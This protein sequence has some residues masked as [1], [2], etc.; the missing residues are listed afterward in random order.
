MSVSLKHEISELTFQVFH[1]PSNS[2][3]KALVRLILLGLLFC[4]HGTLLAEEAANESSDIQEVQGGI[5]PS[6]NAVQDDSSFQ[7]TSPSVTLPT[8]PLPLPP[9]LQESTSEQQPQQEQPKPEETPAVEFN[10][11]TAENLNLPSA[12]PA[13]NPEFA[14]ASVGMPAPKL[15]EAMPGA[16]DSGFGPGPGPLG[17]MFDWAKKLRFQAS[18]RGGYDSNI[19]S[20][21]NN[22]VA[23]PFGNLNGAV[24]YRFGAPRLNVNVDLTGGITQYSNA[25]ANQSLQGVIG[26]RVGVDYR[27]SPRLIFT[28]NTSTSFQQQPNPGLIGTSQNQ[29]GSYIYSANSI[30]AA[31]QWSELF[32]TVTR[33][34]FTGNYYLDSSLNNQQ[35]FTQPGFSQSF[36]WLVKPT[37]TAVLDYNTD[38]YDYV[39]EGNSSWGQS[40]AGGFDHIF[41]PKW[42]WNFRGGAEFRTYQNSNQDG[43]Y[44]GPYL[45]NNFSLSFGK[46]SSVSWLTHI[47]T[48]AS[49]Q[50]NVSFSPAIRTGLN[51]T[52]GLTPSL[53]M[54]SGFFYLI[55]KYNDSNLGPNGALIDYYQSTVQ[56]NIDLSYA[57]NRIFQVALGYQYLTAI[58]P[59][60]PSQEYNRGIS[61]L[62]IK[63]AF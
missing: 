27:F 10:P 60:V 56:A 24:N 12:Q 40:L 13:G 15:D 16:Q 8:P 53:K 32:T 28:F 9:P 37:T 26:L 19:N 14:P 57:L 62:Q 63:G 6:R 48:Q 4:S 38:V 22:A 55:Q 29:N 43:V 17:G 46:E 52:Q 42:F 25:G 54:N 61:Y 30:S 41:N 7:V 50:Q 59:S 1:S 20:S 5:T 58:S 18:V 23:S 47:G 3:P 44:I 33:L 35:G 39:Q 45:D 31:Y 21:Q 34:N 2:N 36:R 51:Y 49:G 11:P